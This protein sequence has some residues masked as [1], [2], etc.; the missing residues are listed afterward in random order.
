MNPIEQ[1][2]PINSRPIT[3]VNVPTH[4]LFCR[5]ELV[6]VEEIKDNHTY[7]KQCNTCPNKK[8]VWS[9]LSLGG[10]PNEKYLP[11]MRVAWW[12]D[13][14]NIIGE[15]YYIVIYLDDLTI[16]FDLNNSLIK[17]FEEFPTV[18]HSYQHLY[19]GPAPEIDWSITESEFRQK[20]KTYLVFL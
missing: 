6:I 19:T 17:I 1:N 2:I 15:P 12:S 14:T 7:H 13:S 16:E 18:T 11:I 20:I 4:C 9:L 3:H 10:A 8:I 5:N